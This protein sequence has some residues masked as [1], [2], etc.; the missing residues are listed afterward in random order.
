MKIIYPILLTALWACATIKVEGVWPPALPKASL[1]AFSEQLTLP[2]NRRLAGFADS[3][4]SYTST[5]A[6]PNV[7][8]NVVLETHAEGLS[9]PL[10]EKIQIQLRNIESVRRIALPNLPALPA[11]PRFSTRPACG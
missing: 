2:A 1:A 5:N 11:L 8:V 3:T 9:R 7:T 4:D 10:E 6:S